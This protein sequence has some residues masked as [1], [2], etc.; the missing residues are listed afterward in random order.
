MTAR[1]LQRFLR[2]N[3]YPL[4]FAALIFTA[5]WFILKGQT[6]TFP[7]VQV[8]KNALLV[9]DQRPGLAARVEL[10]ALDRP[11]FVVIQYAIVRPGARSY[12]GATPLLKVGEHQGIEIV[13][14]SPSKHGEGYVAVLYADDGDGRFDPLLDKPIADVWKNPIAALFHT[15][16]SARDSWDIRF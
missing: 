11:G 12:A 15:L 8:G 13:L 10:A 2:T 6:I 14:S 5:G 4:L 16:D 7:G 3:S 9:V 1:A